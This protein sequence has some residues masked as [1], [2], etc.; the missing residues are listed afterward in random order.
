MTKIIQ[1]DN[2]FNIILKY[3]NL[4]CPNKLNL[5]YTNYY[6]L[7]NIINILSDVV[8]WSSLKITTNY[9][10]TKRYHYKTINKIHLLWSKMKV[11]EDAF[12]EISNNTISCNITENMYID[13]TLII[14]KSGIE[15]IGFGGAYRKKKFTSLTAVC[16][17]N[18]K[19]IKIFPNNTN[20]KVIKYK[21]KEYKLKTFE[22]DSK[23]IIPSIELI[24]TDKKY[25]L[26]GDTGYIINQ[27]KI[28]KYAHVTLIT[29]K[30]QNQKTTNSEENKQK[31]SK[32]YRVENLFAK[33]K[34][35]NRIHVRRDKKL[36]SYLGFV[37]I[38]C[39]AI[40]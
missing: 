25:N 34:R 12:T 5:L 35:F 26:I 37:Y 28:S 22:H 29:Y 13:G 9:N 20:T 30:R 16:N 17:E 33:L 7:S 14:N 2:N 18:T 23:G 19:C 31:L 1:G 10:N 15:G 36:I 6:Y 21:D 11:Y 8:T 32:R 39:I 38:G 27:D 3:A 24:K 4:Y 40:I